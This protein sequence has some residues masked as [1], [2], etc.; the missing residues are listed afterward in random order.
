MHLFGGA[1]GERS[2]VHAKARKIVLK[3]FVFLLLDLLALPFAIVTLLSWRGSSLIGSLLAAP[4]FYT[5]FAA[6]AM[7]EFVKYAVDIPVL[8]LLLIVLPFRPVATVRMLLQDRKHE[9]SC[10]LK[11]LMHRF[12]DIEAARSKSRADIATAQSHYLKEGVV[13]L[14]LR[15]DVQDDVDDF[16]LLAQTR[17][18]LT[19]AAREELAGFS[20]EL[21]VAP[22]SEKTLSDELTKPFA[23]V[24]YATDSFESVANNYILKVENLN[25]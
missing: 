2:G 25:P 24:K 14:G 23:A 13:P 7:N 8:L 5:F 17:Q 1:G 16:Q 22:V 21:E 3:H 6:T 19:W 4:D 18:N 15:E 9:K 12:P 11:D 10:E 20:P